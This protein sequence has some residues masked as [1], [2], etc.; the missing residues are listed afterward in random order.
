[1]ATTLSAIPHGTGIVEELAMQSIA[2]IQQEMSLWTRRY[3]LGRC[4]ATGGRIQQCAGCQSG[5]THEIDIENPQPP[6][7]QDYPATLHSL[8][9]IIAA[10]WE[11]AGLATDF[12]TR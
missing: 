2:V 9:D 6:H 5:E 7:L 8:Y 4:P 10:Q 1:M 11:K 3:E 12:P